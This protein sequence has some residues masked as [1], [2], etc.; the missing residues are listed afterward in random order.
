MEN[1]QIWTKEVE[2]DIYVQK[3]LEK[4][5]LKSSIDFKVKDSSPFLKEALK[6][7]SKTKAKTGTAIPDFT[8]EKYKNDKNELIPIIFENKLGL[9]KLAKF[10]KEPSSKSEEISLKD[11]DISKYALNGALHYAKSVIENSDYKEVLSVGIA[12]DSVKNVSVKI[13][14]VYGS[15]LFANKI[16]KDITNLDFLENQASF[17]SFYKSLIL[18]EQEKHELIIKTQNFLQDHAKK[19]NKLMHNLNITAPQRVLYI[20][21][22]L[23]SMQDIHTEHNIQSGL[24]PEKL[25]GSSIESER[26]G[27]KIFNRINAFLDLKINDKTKLNLMLESFKEI[28]K[29]KLR[30]EIPTKNTA[31]DAQATNQKQV[32]N[33][34]KELSSP[35][36]QI[37]TYI[38][39]YIFSA[40]KI[41]GYADIMGEMYSE[42]LKYALGDGKELGIVLTPPYVTKMMAQ[43][44][45]TSEND[46]VMDLA[47]GSAGFLIAS[48]ELMKDCIISKY[49]KNTTKSKELINKM[50][51]TQLLGV[52]LNAE[53]FTLA[54]TNM[55][56][57]GD[58]SSNI[59]KANTF[60]T[61]ESLYENFKATRLLLNPPF[62]FDEN[63]MPF[64]KFGL[65]KMQK[66][67]LAAIIIQDSAGSGKAMKSNQEILK[68]HTL[69][70]SIKMPP[71]LFQ[72]M[73]GVQTS[74]YIF[75]AHI[76]HDFEKPVKF[77][78]F[79]FDGYKRTDRKLYEIDKPTQRYSDIIK[80]YKAGKNAQIDN[81]VYENPINLDEIYV[82]DFIN[83][84]G[85]DWNFD[86]H[87]KI[88]TKPTLQDFKKCVGEYLAWEVSNILKSQRESNRPF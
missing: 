17:L 4:L 34:L 71:D 57:R 38:Y 70:A 16:L 50:K 45:N 12:G 76:P 84:S 14:Y 21:G 46:K 13:A 53:M 78:D 18:T 9:N 15:G 5:N 44:L 42:F 41:E 58:G 86:A 7:A 2:V 31:T 59:Q 1:T 56:L 73:A 74:I 77:I 81:S 43:I 87:K 11:D 85:N 62:T 35:N 26:D 3:E 47:T 64:M 63:G 79:R 88:D 83:E 20:S 72:P 27:I 25:E 19:L 29:D 32:E 22:M 61:P 40:I 24:K 51:K 48:M 82:E 54:A 37:F 36:K 10:T 55:I 8:I 69:L 66:A 39:H 23:L 68:H 75:E 80:I 65:S 52:E 49:G 30:D 60:D 33:I 67:G 28:C 6:G